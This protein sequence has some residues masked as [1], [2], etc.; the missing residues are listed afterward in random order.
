[1]PL[2]AAAL[3]TWFATETRQ[4]PVGLA[5]IL[6]AGLWLFAVSIPEYVPLTR[7]WRFRTRVVGWSLVA[8]VTLV[9][10]ITVLLAPVGGLLAFVA[11]D[12]SRRDNRQAT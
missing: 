8:S 5:A 4:G 10:A 6:A 11:L 7:T 3:I 12:F 9:P 1:L 2:A